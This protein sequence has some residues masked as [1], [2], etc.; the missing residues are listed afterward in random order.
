[1]FQ[2]FYIPSGFLSRFDWHYFL[3]DGKGL[4]RDGAKNVFEAVWKAKKR[5]LF[6]SRVWD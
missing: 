5:N 4:V 1:M 6:I 2:C 3:Y